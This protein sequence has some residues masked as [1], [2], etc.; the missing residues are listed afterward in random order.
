MTRRI[1]AREA[2][3]THLGYDYAE[4]EDYRYQPTRTTVPV[5][6]VREAYYCAPTSRQAPPIGWRWGQCATVLN[7]AI[8][9][10]STEA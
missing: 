4:M 3:A 8:L 6:A 9:S 2:I 7:R 10:A 5:Y 1:T